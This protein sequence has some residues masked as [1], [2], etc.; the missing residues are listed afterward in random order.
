MKLRPWPAT[1]NMLAQHKTPPPLSSCQ[2]LIYSCCSCSRSLL[3]LLLLPQRLLHAVCRRAAAQWMLTEPCCPPMIYILQSCFV[4][5]QSAD[6][7]IR[8]RIISVPLFKIQICESIPA[9]LRALN[10][11]LLFRSSSVTQNRGKQWR[12][13]D[14]S[15]VIDWRCSNVKS[16]M[17][18][19]HQFVPSTGRSR[20]RS[21]MATKLQAA[22]CLSEPQKKNRKEPMQNRQ[23]KNS[24][25]EMEAFFRYWLALDGLRLDSAHHH[26]SNHH[27][28]IGHAHWST[29]HQ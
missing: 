26:S 7:W 25:N 2:P 1:A 21:S 5:L 24:S 10:T 29:V 23:K 15:F 17:S 4:R 27:R 9:H 20:G 13:R 6:V 18:D 28:W 12:I 11:G 19:I 22:N 8:V 3:L 14:W 16:E